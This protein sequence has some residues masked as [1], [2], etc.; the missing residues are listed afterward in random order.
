MNWLIFI[1]GMGA[2]IITILA[3]VI[4]F[5]LIHS[6]KTDS[7]N[8]SLLEHWDTNHRNLGYQI[9]ELKRI[10]IAIENFVSWKRIKG[11]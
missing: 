10:A 5:N 9:E 7:F 4:I 8:A 6:K 3:V 1:A 2:G 11:E